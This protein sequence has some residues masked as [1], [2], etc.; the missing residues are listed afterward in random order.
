[1]YRVRATDGLSGKSHSVSLGPGGAIIK[2]PPLLPSAI[3]QASATGDN[4]C[5]H[6]SSVGWE[7]GADWRPQCRCLSSQVGM[8]SGGC[9]V[10]SVV[11]R[12]N[13]PTSEGWRRKAGTEPSKI[14][15]NRRR[16]QTRPPPRRR[17]G[18]GIKRRARRRAQSIDPVIVAVFSR[19]RRKEEPRPK[20]LGLGR[21]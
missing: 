21:I 2:P 12:A 13:T 19:M 6:K 8:A 3:N 14:V 1:M 4:P 7:A 16:R 15:C 10:D 18:G 20:M 11:E 9:R 5:V 17:N